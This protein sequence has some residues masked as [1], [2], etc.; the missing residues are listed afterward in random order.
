MKYHKGFETVFTAAH[1]MGHSLGMEHDGESFNKKCDPANFLMAAIAGPGQINWSQCSNQNVKNFLASGDP[2]ASV[3]DPNGVP[4][5]LT[6]RGSRKAGI[7]YR[8]GKWPGTIFDVKRQCEQAC[9]QC[10][11]YILNQKPYN[12]RKPSIIL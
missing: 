12:V 6:K 8:T 3:K 7:R 11:P 5:C 2:R 10:T 1:E 4:K 9:N